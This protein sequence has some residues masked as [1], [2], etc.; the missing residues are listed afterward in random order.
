VRRSSLVNE[1]KRR[2][3]DPVAGG[4]TRMPVM[5]AYRQQALVCAASMSGAPSRPRE[6]KRYSPD[7]QKILA[8]NVYGWF[9]RVE[10]GLYTLTDAGRTALATWGPVPNQQSSMWLEEEQ[11]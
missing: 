7:A 5:T 4:G 11:C 2:E 9:E 10:R 6:L 1:H 3:G 8:H